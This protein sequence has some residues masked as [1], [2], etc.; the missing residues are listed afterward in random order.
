MVWVNGGA[1][2]QA[3][4]NPSLP[5][6]KTVKSEETEKAIGSKSV[7]QGY[8]ELLITDHLSFT[9]LSLIELPLEKNA[10]PWLS[11]E[12]MVLVGLYVARRL[13]G[14]SRNGPLIEKDWPRTGHPIWIACLNMWLR[15]VIT[16]PPWLSS[17]DV[18]CSTLV[19][20]LLST[21][22]VHTE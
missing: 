10:M 11:Y 12:T 4:P 17:F 9:C 5:L 20:T 19:I 2:V 22:G 8:A 15:W 7:R 16:W 14:T 6:L 21:A 13:G 18:V 3:R 1:R